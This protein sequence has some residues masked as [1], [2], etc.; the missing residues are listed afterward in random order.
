MVFYDSEKWSS[1]KNLIG[2]KGWMGGFGR[3][4]D[5]N[6]FTESMH[7]NMTWQFCGSRFPSLRTLAM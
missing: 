4:I 2:R 1:G 5:E 7:E 6:E 3:T